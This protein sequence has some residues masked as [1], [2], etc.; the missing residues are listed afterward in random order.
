MK[1]YRMRQYS[2]LILLMVRIICHLFIEAGIREGV[3]MI[4]R[5][6]AKSN[7]PGEVEYDSEQPTEHLIY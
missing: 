1:Y 6:F 3:S 5:R 4:T 2:L 7:I